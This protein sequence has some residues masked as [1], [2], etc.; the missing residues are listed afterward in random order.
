[1]STGRPFGAVIGRAVVGAPPALPSLASLR[2]GDVPL[3]GWDWANPRPLPAPL[4]QPSADA[5]LAKRI[6][7]LT[8]ALR[9]AGD[10]NA[11][12]ERGQAELLK[13]ARKNT[14]AFTSLPKNMN[15]HVTKVED[16]AKQRTA[17]TEKL[18]TDSLSGVKKL[19]AETTEKQTTESAALAEKL[20]ALIDSLSKQQA[21]SSD[22]LATKLQSQLSVLHDKQD[23]KY[24]TSITRLSNETQTAAEKLLEMTTESQT[25]A[26]AALAKEQEAFIKKLTDSSTARAEGLE[27]F[28][29]KLVE[30][31]TNS[32]DAR[33]DELKALPSQFATV[34]METK[35]L[36]QQN[37]ST[38]ALTES[39][40]TLIEKLDEQQTV[41]SD[42]RADEQK[43]FSALLEAINL[44][45][46]GILG[47]AKKAQ[48]TA[49]AA[50][51]KEQE[52]FI[53]KLDAQQ[54]DSSD[55]RVE[56]LDRLARTL[57]ERL[58]EGTAALTLQS[59]ALA[60]KLQELNE[61]LDKQHTDEFDGEVVS[62]Q[63][64]ETAFWEELPELSY[65]PFK[66]LTANGTTS[67]S[68]E[69][70]DAEA[71]EDFNG[72][73]TA[74]TQQSDPDGLLSAIEGLSISVP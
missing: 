63:H 49:A 53:K 37:A 67:D 55:A 31:Q 69:Q 39:L 26:S 12:A 4:V 19:L 8:E 57:G 65:S 59:A 1:M 44:A 61:K 20:Q 68:S 7:Q 3:Y 62:Q 73:E 11:A 52:V 72:A 16:R 60:E 15:E 45:R 41:A 50:L 40:Q 71:V 38:A 2:V 43:T 27:A 51:A 25:K 10:R 34:L 35:T 21:A 54:A 70:D 29:E 28:I 6:E 66:V 18:V 24:E 33:A 36:Q 32:S 46:K 56:E 14:A 48:T 64:D 5:G 17:I 23:V 42:A 47:A 30:L 9:D 74:S 22:A 13:R 58:E